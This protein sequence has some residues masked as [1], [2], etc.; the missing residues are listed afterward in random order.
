MTISDRIRVKDVRLLSDNYAVLKTTTLDYR[1]ANGEWQTQRR[2]TYDR[3]NSTGRDPNVDYVMLG[4]PHYTIE[5]I[6]EAA[7]LIEGRK[8]H[9]DC[10]L[11]IFTPRAIKSL[12]LASPPLRPP[13]TTACRARSASSFSATAS[14]STTTCIIRCNPA[15][16][17]TAK[18][19]R[20]RK[21]CWSIRAYRAIW[22]TRALRPRK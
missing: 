18:A 6:W 20:A 1:R 4:C 15:L 12:G 17:M 22:Y 7:Q 3:L 14:R 13:L 10:E 9:P 11:W 5:Q 16:R 21:Y 19:S 8:V 2:E